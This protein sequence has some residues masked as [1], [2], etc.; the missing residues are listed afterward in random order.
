[1]RERPSRYPHSP[2]TQENCLGITSH[3]E[4]LQR[5]A[6]IGKPIPH[7][8]EATPVPCSIPAPRPTAPYGGVVAGG[9]QGYRAQPM[10]WLE[11]S[12]RGHGFNLKPKHTHPKF[13]AAGQDLGHVDRDRESRGEENPKAM[14]GRSRRT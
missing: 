14:E 11:A 3:A 5:A 13:G 4:A 8:G 6:S 7:P 9:A 1:M 2:S 10:G 12:Q